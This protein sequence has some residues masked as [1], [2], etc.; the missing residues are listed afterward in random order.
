MGSILLGPGGA[1]ARRLGNYEDRPQQLA[2][3]KAVAEAI[4][5]RHHLMVEAG[6]GG[7]KSFAYLAPALAAALDNPEVRIVVSTHTINLQEQLINKDIPF[8]MS[9]LPKPVPT[10]LVKGRAN[11]LSKRRLRVAGQRAANLLT[12]E[13]A[14]DQLQ[15]IQA[16]AGASKIGSRHD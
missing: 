2:M 9:L 7:G 16:W 10:L 1:V 13:A 6:T 12:E 4:A 15:E 5:E 8:L 11:Y 3:A 14:Q